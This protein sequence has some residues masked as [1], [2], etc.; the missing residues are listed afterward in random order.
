M[1]IPVK[2]DGI[3]KKFGA[4]SAVRNVSLAINAGEIFFLL[5]PSGCGKTTLLRCIAGFY[6][7]DAGRICMGDRDISAL[8]PERRDA[9]MVFQSYALWPHMTVQQN[10][11]FGLEMR[12]IPSGERRTLV[13][14]ALELVRMQDYAA[15]RPGELS[16]GQQQRVALARALV[17]KP[18]CLLLDEPLSNLDAKLRL[19]MRSEIRRLCK[20]AGVTA[21]YV[22]HDQKEALSIADRLAVMRDGVVEQCGPPLDVYRSPVN[23]FVAG[24]MGET[25]LFKAELVE[26][27]KDQSVRIST[28]AGGLTGVPG[29]TLA[30][31]AAGQTVT[32]SIRPECF[33]LVDDNQSGNSVAGT[34][35]E[36]IFLGDSAQYRVVLRD[37]FRIK[38]Q[39]ANPV[40]M[41]HAGD[42]LFLRVDPRDVLVFADGV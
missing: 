3:T 42:Q 9:A 32:V 6:K 40:I 28:P 36:N 27:V 14:S 25:N 11:E 23:P 37:G 26:C 30:A 20:A 13:A 33:E 31:P 34:L 41:R 19:D 17:V 24:F 16:G 12:R 18:R 35:E 5:G 38:V 2:L 1:G 22:T 39:E 8:P 4:V 10:V 21:I 7:P 15:R 29:G